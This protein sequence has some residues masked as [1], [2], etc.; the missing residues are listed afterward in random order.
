MP[1]AA[2]RRRTLRSLAA[3][4]GLLVAG[5]CRAPEPPGAAPPAA[6]APPASA[7]SGFVLISIDTLRAD[8]VGAYGYPRPTTPFLD[9]LAA[10]GV[11]FERATTPIPATLP[12]HLSMF[13]GLYPGEHDAYPPSGVLA[14]EIP[15]LPELFRAA[16]Y[17]TAGHSEGGFVAG[18]FG[19]A[20]GF[21]VWSDTDYSADTD[22]DRTFGRGAE[23]LRSLAPGERFFLFLHTYAVHDPYAPPAGA[24]GEFWP[25]EPP[26]GAFEPTGENLA[27]FNRGQG[28]VDAAALDWYRALYDA[29]IRHVDAALERLWGELERAGLAGRTVLVITSDHGEEFLEHGR[30]AHTQVYRESLE[31]P[32]VV[33]TPGD[34]RPRRVRSLV[35]LPDLL[36]T[37]VDLAGLEMPARVSGSSLAPLLGD[38]ALPFS[39]DAYA[40]DEE[41]GGHERTLIAAGADGLWQLVRGTVDVEAD[42]FWVSREVRFDVFGDDLE[43]RAVAF[44]E[45][46]RVTI[47]VDG[48][49]AGAIE[50]G[51]DWTP[52]RIA[53]PGEGKRTVTMRAAGCR[54]PAS[55]GGSDDTRCLSFKLQGVALGRVELYRTDADPRQARDLSAAERARLRDLS[56]RLDRVRHVPVA[57]AGRAALSDEQVRQLRALGYLD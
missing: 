23:F 12:A 5:A 10:R 40:E 18:G 16:G 32:L 26:A 42:G 13:T 54:T 22:V 53:L 24:L 47:E 21:E 43:L 28:A 25:G 9:R 30:L 8:H 29:S 55:L 14:A 50:L 52:H 49:P 48:R 51:T 39:R 11:V 6:A 45:P 15:T 33:V 37:F 56:A 3:I 31:I 7:P 34:L 1:I 35:Q 4:A 36:P 27:A 20:R 44:H 17:R 38:P 46:R 19:F 41:P 57:R 2:P